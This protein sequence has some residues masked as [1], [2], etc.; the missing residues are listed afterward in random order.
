MFVVLKAVAIFYV[1]TIVLTGLVTPWQKVVRAIL[2]HRPINRKLAVTGR[3]VA[4][5][6]L[7]DCPV[8]AVAL[9]VAGIKKLGVMGISRWIAIG[10]ALHMLAMT[11]HMDLYSELQILEHGMVATMLLGQHCI[12]LELR[13]RYEADFRTAYE[14]LATYFTGQ[15]RQLALPEGKH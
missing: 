11:K 7:F 15:P 14:L 12:A 5:T 1:A 13:D 3:W 9:V 8:L 6:V 4:R 2:I 10:A